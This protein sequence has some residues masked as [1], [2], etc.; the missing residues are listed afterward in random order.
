MAN[1]K[2]I[3]QRIVSVK[4]TQQV[5]KAMKMVSAAKLRKAQDRIT[6][7]RPYA[8]KLKEIMSNITGNVDPSSISS[9]FVQERA[10]E[11]VLVIV[12]SSNR[13]L[14][15]AFNSAISKHAESVING[16]F[17][18]QK[19][20]GNL[21]VLNIGKKTFEYFNRRKYNL[22]GENHDVFADLSF[23]TVSD[24]ADIVLDGFIEGKWDRVELV[25]NE[26][27]N[28]L[29]QERVNEQYLP[30]AAVESGDSEEKST[31]NADYI[32]EPDQATILEDLIPKSL[33]LALYRAVLE[34]NAGEQG[35]RMAAMDSAT[36]NAEGLIKELRLKYNQARQA[37]IT[38][39]LLEIV[40]GAEALD[41]GA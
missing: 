5:T 16:Q 19:A 37:A 12:V 17:A 8:L 18:E 33:R 34:S 1:L 41:S 22:V 13:G 24:V 28:V 40:A 2:E 7:L 4:S 35:A 29:V 27:K 32:F 30:V 23:E 3:R 21:Q 11:K 38:T 9:P 25:F 26:F 6:A 36:E 39:E 20:A 31:G 10:P 14:C 15:G